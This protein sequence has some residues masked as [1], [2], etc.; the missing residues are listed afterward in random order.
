MLIVRSCLSVKKW[1]VDSKH[2]VKTLFKF[3]PLQLASVFY[4]LCENLSKEWELKYPNVS[5]YSIY[6]CRSWFY[7]S[8]V[9]INEQIIMESKCANIVK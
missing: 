7:F 1:V 9:Q 2:I 3:L 5:E 6:F 4:H 8:S